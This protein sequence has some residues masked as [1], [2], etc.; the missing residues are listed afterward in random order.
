MLHVLGCAYAG[1]TVKVQQPPAERP[2]RPV[3]LR[4]LVH[5]FVH[6]QTVNTRSLSPN[7]VKSRSV[8]QPSFP[9][10]AWLIERHKER[11]WA[12]DTVRQ[13][14]L[15]LVHHGRPM[16]SAPRSPSGC[17]FGIDL[18]NIL[19]SSVTALP[20]YSVPSGTCAGVAQRFG[21]ETDPSH[22][23]NQQYQRQVALP[24][25]LPI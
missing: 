1:R 21:V 8:S 13:S 2:S 20:I 5:P 17:S 11:I 25:R 14:T 24:R 7:I 18:T 3:R 16:T 4:G 23:L 22:S 10:T 15:L 6:H 12:L 19:P 9:Q